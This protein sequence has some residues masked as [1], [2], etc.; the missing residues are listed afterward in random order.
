M[1]LMEPFFDPYLPMVKLAGGIPKFIGIKP[2][3]GKDASTAENWSFD[4]TE[5]AGLFSDKT[6]AIIV[7]T[8][9]NPLGKVFSEKELQFVA[10]LCK[11]FGTVVIAD[12]VYEHLTY[13]NE[14]VRMGNLENMFEQTLTIGSAGKTFGVT[15]WKVGWTIGP[16]YLIKA[17]QLYCVSTTAFTPTP[18]QD[19]VANAINQEISK[20]K[21]ENY[22]NSLKKEL[23]PKRERLLEMARKAGFKPV[24]PQGGYFVVA[25]ASGIS[26]DKSNLDMEME[27]E[28]GKTRS[29]DHALARYLLKHKDLAVIPTSP[30]YH[31]NSDNN[32]KRYVRFC[33][34]KTDET[35]EAAERLFSEW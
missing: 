1:I 12:E 11:K 33:F 14:L 5:L 34:A 21:E 31:E 6:K 24:T 35:L 32:E 9:H 23:L 13:E 18:T 20:P 28:T 22:F 16:D 29:F 7:N 25:D 3:P 8:P 27:T 19:A 4:E 17:M 10:D 26:F 2:I 15:G 30:F